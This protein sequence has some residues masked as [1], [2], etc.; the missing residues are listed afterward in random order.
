MSVSGERVPT[1]SKGLDTMLG[2][3]FLKGSASLIE[4]SA[5]TGKTTLGVQFIMEGITRGEN[6]LIATFEE[7][8][9][10]YYDCAL[11]LGWDLKSAEEAGTLT[12]IFTTPEE[13]L[14][15]LEESD[16]R[17]T[18]LVE[19]KKIKRVLIDS[20]T[21]FEKLSLDIGQLR[22]IE[23]ALVNGLKR[24]SATTVLLKENPNVLGGWSITA[25]KIPFIVDTYLLLRYVEVK[26]EI[27]RCL[28]ILK[29][30]G[31]DHDK[32]IREYQIGENGVE[33]G[34]PFKDMAGLFLGTGH[35]VSAVKA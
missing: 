19:D 31:S 12:I 10:Q 8:P 30:R 13:F 6:G 7:F 22:Q 21:H 27:K 11:E 25:N 24:E 33:I 20:V 3:G 14:E 4:G 1:G 17:I 2:G 29:M 32:S 34:E 9:Q 28:M 18:Q 35:S 15:Q 5:G 26:S 16:G 23:T